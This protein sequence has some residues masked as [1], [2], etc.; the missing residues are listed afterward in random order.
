MICSFFG[1]PVISGEAGAVHPTGAG[2]DEFTAL[3]LGGPHWRLVPHREAPGPGD[4][5][6]LFW[7]MGE[8]EGYMETYI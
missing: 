6:A 5:V 4:D 2:S 3:R 1:S 8:R 7:E